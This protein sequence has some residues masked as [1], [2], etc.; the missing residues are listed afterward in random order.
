[1]SDATEK[2]AG[3]ALL[4]PA[5][6]VLLM[7]RGD[8]GDYPG[9]W[10]F[11]GGHREDGE[12][13]EE[14]ARRET[15]EET[16]RVVT[17]ELR[18]IMSD[19]HFKTYAAVIPEAFPVQMCHESTGA[20]WASLDDLPYPLHPGVRD[21]LDIATMST[22]L[23]AARLV[24]RGV[25]PSGFKYMNVSLF[26]M[27][28]TGTGVAW[29]SALNE[30]TYRPPEYYMNDEFLQRCQ[31][32]PVVWMHP[33]GDDVGIMKSDEYDD[34]NI[35]SLFLPYLKHDVQE[36]WAIAKVWDD[37]AADIMREKQLSTSPGVFVAPI[38]KQGDNESGQIYIEGKPQLIDHLAICP[39]GVW[40]KGGEPAGVTL[41]T[42]GAEIMDGEVK[43]DGAP[44][45][46]TPD[47]AQVMAA[48]Q[49]IAADN[50][51]IRARLDSADAEAEKAKKD[52][53]EAEKAKKDAEEAEAA[54]KARKDAEEAEKAKKDAEAAAELAARMAA[55]SAEEMN[56]KA[57]YCA[58][59]DSALA[60]VG[61]RV[62]PPLP[63]ERAADYRIRALATAQ[64]YA[65]DA[66][67]RIDLQLARKDAALLEMS[68]ARILQSVADR[69]RT[70]ASQASKLVE[71]KREIGGRMVR[72]FIGPVSAFLAPF[73]LPA[74]RVVKI[75]KPG[76]R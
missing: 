7:K 40:D 19:G 11:P 71:I 57:D 18:E 69:A 15:L 59:M 17:D 30:I 4:T 10:G 36:V 75:N 5:R 12:T 44:G 2:A 52:A 54:E 6:Q 56:M 55:D 32:L 46:T 63:G 50:Q 38:L 48:I 14:T 58:R 74:K 29:R 68:E 26:D 67:Q 37:A 43:K 72:E 34:Q 22:E 16:G 20:L 8:G 13:L 66:E 51:K 23:D 61:Q 47:L 62:S 9:T 73:T 65:G 24:M 42:T 60:A 76:A 28:V 49:Q 21:A 45:G 70:V 31:G 64:K 25:L 35:G 41:S 33:N 27:R 39:Q 53:E 1:M 3:I